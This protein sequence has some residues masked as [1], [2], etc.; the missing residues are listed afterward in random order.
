M[1]NNKNKFSPYLEQLNIFFKKGYNIY[2][3]D[4][5]EIVGVPGVGK[6]TLIKNLKLYYSSITCKDE[7]VEEWK[8]INLFDNKNL[9]EVQFKITIDLLFG[10]HLSKNQLL[11]SNYV[12]TYAHTR[13]KYEMNILTKEE[14]NFFEENIFSKIK[15]KSHKCI[16]L[17]VDS[18]D[19]IIDRMNKRDKEHDKNI[20]NDD[21]INKLTKH[22]EDIIKEKGI[23]SIYIDSTNSE[24]EVCENIIKTINSFFNI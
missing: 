2:D 13:Y 21:Y 18:N 7:P 12:A 17:K 3:N 4:F 10:E 20:R 24:I 6:S 11:V 8:K 22:I 16:I 14:Y 9:F 15:L 1:D 19:I 5:I 23:I